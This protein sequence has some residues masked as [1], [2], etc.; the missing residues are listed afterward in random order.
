[1]NLNDA[2][3]RKSIEKVRD[4]GRQRRGCFSARIAIHGPQV[5]DI[6]NE[7]A[8]RMLSHNAEE[9]LNA[10]VA[11]F[12]VRQRRHFEEQQRLDRALERMLTWLPRLWYVAALVLGAAFA[13]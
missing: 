5:P 8:T 13:F 3:E 1:M 11:E 4:E 2:F 12:E 7:P 10:D 9:F 6:Q